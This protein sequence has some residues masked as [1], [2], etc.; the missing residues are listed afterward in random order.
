MHWISTLNTFAP[1]FTGDRR[2]PDRCS[3]CRNLDSKVEIFAAPLHRSPCWAPDLI[4]L[5]LG[6]SPRRIP[7][8]SRRQL[9]L[10]VGPQYALGGALCRN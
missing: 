4:V 2:Y 5:T 6:N 9:P 1:F 8:Q 7:H 10:L 3:M